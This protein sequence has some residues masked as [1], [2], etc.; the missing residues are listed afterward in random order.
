MGLR[1]PIPKAVQ[2]LCEH[3]LICPSQLAPNSFST[4]LALGVLLKY[5]GIPLSVALL[6]RFVQ[7]KRKEI[8]R[9]YVSPRPGCDFLVGNPSSHKGWMNRYFYVESEPF[10]WYCDMTW[11][12]Q[13]TLR[14]PPAPGRA[15]DLTNFLASIS[16]KCFDVKSLIQDDLLCEFRFC[17]K[18]IEVEGDI[19]ER[20]MKSAML[21]NMKRRKGEAGNSSKSSTAEARGKQKKLPLDSD[22]QPVKKVLRITTSSPISKGSGKGPLSSST[23]PDTRDFEEVNREA[24]LDHGTSFIARPSG[25]KALNFVRH[26]VSSEDL[27]LVKAATDLQ[28]MESM[29]L[30][31]MQVNI[32]VSFVFTVLL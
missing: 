26:L 21:E 20:I 32:F 8:G 19:D 31:F 11:A 28:A 3:Y 24:P 2:Y 4:L 7:I 9:F 1:F 13:L 23:V 22:E 27:A 15:I 18:G 17:R 5:F 25:P 6:D 12:E 10:P 29:S 30:N 14:D 16:E